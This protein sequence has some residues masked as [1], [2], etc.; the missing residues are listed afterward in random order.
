MRSPSFVLLAL[1]A[2]PGR[3]PAQTGPQPSVVLTILGGV[4]AGHDLWSLGK[5][6]LN[7]IGTGTFDTLA[8]SR[9]VESSLI[10]GATGTYFINPSL[11]LHAELSYLGLPL[12]NTCILL[13]PEQ[14][15]GNEHKNQQLCDNVNATA[16]SGGAI[17]IF[18]G[19]TLRAASR[20]T[21][22]PY[23]RAS[24]GIINLSRSTVEV[25]GSYV[26]AGGIQDRAI[27]ADPSPRE[28]SMMLGLAAGFTTP[29]AEGY[30]LR[31]EVRDAVTSLERVVQATNLGDPTIDSRTYH[32]FAL[33]IGFD[34]VLER[35]RRRRY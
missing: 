15:D 24:V 28:R 18:V 31:L 20:R 2:L 19:A 33:V 22:S 29:V 35:A 27:I 23:L 16:G 21:V 10:L 3:A 12:D 32:H 7:V 13:P 17:A 30:Q 14:P 6:P 8:L 9:S 34:I 4:G 26:D 25:A 5:Q 11:G 1:L